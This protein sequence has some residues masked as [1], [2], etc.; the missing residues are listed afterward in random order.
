MVTC[1]IIVVSHNALPYSKIFYNSYRRYTRTD[2]IKLVW[3]DNNSTD[4][5]REW[6]EELNI[7]HLMLL[8]E[9]IGA[10]YARHKA[11]HEIDTDAICFVDNDIAITQI[12]WINR[13]LR[14]LYSSDRIGAVAPAFNLILDATH[15]DAFTERVSRTWARIDT[16]LNDQSASAFLYHEDVQP[17]IDKYLTTLKKKPF[18]GRL[19]LEG[20]GT[21]LRR[22]TYLDSGGYRPEFT[23]KHEGG[24]LHRGIVYKL[25]LETWVVPS[26]FLFHYGHATRNTSVIPDFHQKIKMSEEAKR[27]WEAEDKEFKGR[28]S[29]IQHE[30]ERS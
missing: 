1:S 7:D 25:G 2:N 14:V 20:G 4:G 6:L 24:V 21:T 30:L 5:T 15:F 10:A 26:V 18:P 22:F 19:C 23:I 8:D 13:L 17:Y 9:N 12:G 16:Y 29:I 27:R 28:G 11:V 3:V